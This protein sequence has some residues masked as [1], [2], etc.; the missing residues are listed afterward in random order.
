[1]E[2]IKITDKLTLRQEALRMAIES[3][4]GR[5]NDPI[6]IKMD[7][8][9]F[10]SYIQGS[11]DLPEYVDTSKMFANAMEKMNE[12][13]SQPNPWISADSEM[14]PALNTQVLV[15]CEDY[16]TPLFGEYLGEDYWEVEEADVTLRSKDG[17]VNVLAWTP[18]PP[19]V[20]PLKL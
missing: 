12:R 3:N 15:M 9:Q 5:T 4:K 2:P 10:E 1:M 20:A 13:W 16:T 19:Y 11:A 8:I 14:K 18:I 6:H 7:A 17:E